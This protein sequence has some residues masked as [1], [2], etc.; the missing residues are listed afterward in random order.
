MICLEKTQAL[1]VKQALEKLVRPHDGKNLHQNLAQKLNKNLFSIL[2][3]RDKN[4]QSEEEATAAQPP[5]HF[6]TCGRNKYCTEPFL[7]LSIV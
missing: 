7:I 3:V 6:L 5:I 4:I 1:F 2:Q